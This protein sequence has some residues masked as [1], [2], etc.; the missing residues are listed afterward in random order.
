M[1]EV[2]SP[3]SKKLTA[4]A[5]VT[6][7]AVVSCSLALGAEATQSTIRVGELDRSYLL[8]V[9]DTLAKDQPI[10]LLFVFHGGNGESR[11]I[12]NL[13]KFNPIADRDRFIVVYPQGIGKGWND[14]RATVVSQ[15]HRDNVDDLAFFDAMSSEAS[16]NHSIKS[17][18]PRSLFL[19]S[20]FKAQKILWFPTMGAKFRVAIAKIGVVL[21]QP[22]EQ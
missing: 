14:G 17:F 19:Y 6:V 22:T 15:A 16:P 10:P 13:T 18:S 3:M 12:M 5:I 1:N 20:S 7:L 11:G 21:S 8:Y 2:M 4:I 9:P